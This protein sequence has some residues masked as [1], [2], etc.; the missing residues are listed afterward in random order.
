MLLKLWL[1]LVWVTVAQELQLNQNK[2]TNLSNIV[3]NET[4]KKY[5][6]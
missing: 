1:C 6:V 2:L 5:Q 4:Y 3:K